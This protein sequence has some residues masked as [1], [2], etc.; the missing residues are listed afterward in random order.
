MTESHFEVSSVEREMI[1]YRMEPSSAGL[2]VGFIGNA[3]EVPWIVG[4]NND[5][6]ENNRSKKIKAIALRSLLA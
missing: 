2:S 5:D 3:L 1:L 4:M 6:D